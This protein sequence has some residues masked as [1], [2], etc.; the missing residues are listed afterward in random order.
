MQWQDL[1]AALALVLVVEGI[2]PFLNPASYK[3]T[4]AQMLQLP[5]SNLRVIG[6]GS[7][8]AGLFFLYLVRH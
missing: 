6:L 5:D 3:K 2:L 7:M 1:F 8:I 4:M